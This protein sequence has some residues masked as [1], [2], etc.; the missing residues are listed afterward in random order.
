[1]SVPFGAIRGVPESDVEALVGKRVTRSEHFPPTKNS[2]E[3]LV[4]T[5][6]DGF[7]L[8]IVTS[9]YMHITIIKETTK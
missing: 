3:R 1:M 6:S 7:Q 5:F 4:L 8:S 2:N 9:E